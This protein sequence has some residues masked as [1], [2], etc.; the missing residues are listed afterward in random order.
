[1]GRLAVTDFFGRNQ[2][3]LI[4]QVPCPVHMLWLVISFPFGRWL[5][6]RERT[7]NWMTY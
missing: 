5:V 1:M 2:L 7:G 6:P 3:C 4:N